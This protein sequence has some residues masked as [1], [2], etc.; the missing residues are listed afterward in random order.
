MQ[1]FMESKMWKYFGP[2]KKE[3]K[4][5]DGEG[6][7]ERPNLFKKSLYLPQESGAKFYFTS[8]NF[9]TLSL[10]ILVIC[11]PHFKITENM[12]YFG[13]LL[14]INY[15]WNCKL[16]IVSESCCKIFESII[17]HIFLLDT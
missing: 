17:N 15:L 3:G 12:K 7:G 14:M 10:V 4:L 16:W 13:F 8:N 1:S 6:G 5:D 11:N 2:R 9:N